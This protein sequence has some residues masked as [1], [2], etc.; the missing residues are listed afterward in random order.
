M[1]TRRSIIDMGLAVV[2]GFLSLMCVLT[3]ITLSLGAQVLVF[4]LL[5][6]AGL[7][8]FLGRLAYKRWV[9]K[10]G[11]KQFK[12]KQQHEDVRTLEAGEF[13][14]RVVGTSHANP[15]GSDRQA[16]IKEHCAAGALLTMVREPQ[17]SFD[18][19]AIGVY[20]SGAQIG[21]LTSEI[22]DQYAP[23][24]DAGKLRLSG[25]VTDVT[26][27]TR[28]KPTLGV[29]IVLTRAEQQ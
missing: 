5:M 2:Y 1:S 21:Y 17:N 14:T 7:A 24:I 29:N 23:E 8:F 16:A 20:C 25:R 12:H 22:A 19:N 3:G 10:T 28:Q 15:D 18:S 26:G 13:F 6:C 9:P 4:P 11:L 27:G